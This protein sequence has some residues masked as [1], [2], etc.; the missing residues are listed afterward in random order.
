MCVDQE[1]KAALLGGPSR[2]RPFYQLILPQESGEWQTTSELAHQLH[3]SESDIA[4]KYWEAVRWAQ[5]VT[6]R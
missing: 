3:L 4:E 5:Q 2:W 1:T 6:A